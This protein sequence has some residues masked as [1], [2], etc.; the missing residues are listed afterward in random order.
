MGT[1]FKLEYKL[2]QQTPLI[3]FQSQEEGACL[4]ASEVKPKLDCFIHANRS[5]IPAD[6]YIDKKQS[7][8]LN[9]K[10]K[11]E[12]CGNKLVD[13]PERALFFGKG[14]QTVFYN[15]GLKLTI[16]CFKEDLRSEIEACIRAFFLLHNFGTRQNKGFGSFMVSG[17]KNPTEL[18]KSYVNENCHIYK[19]QY[20]TV[21]TRKDLYGKI[22]A[23]IAELSAML[24]GGIN[25]RTAP[26]IKAFIVEYALKKGIGGDKRYLKQ[27]GIV[28]AL[29]KSAEEEKVHKQLK[30][31]QYRYARAILGS[32]GT[33]T[34]KASEDSSEKIKIKIYTKKEEPVKRIPSPVLYK[35]VNNELFII[36]K[37]LPDAV[38]GKEFFFR[39][40]IKKDKNTPVSKEQ[41]E[42]KTVSLCVPK[43]KELHVR[44]LY[45][46]YVKELNDK[47]SKQISTKNK[48]NRLTY[49]KE[50]KDNQIV[51]L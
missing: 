1:N 20:K 18:L 31:E 48:R 25:V 39:E 12:A 30:E 3:H 46:A 37:R 10:M 50:N 51:R 27:K 19:M 44:E 9:Y 6:W 7:N 26:Y 40:D 28:P 33:Y 23:D 5:P 35:I 36:V 49:F 11:I 42:K 43:E 4:R 22:F 24:R 21:Q 17:T 32:A 34:Y 38:Y 47:N 8:A 15:S 45:D 13:E 29:G 41:D 16:L 14:K 2:I